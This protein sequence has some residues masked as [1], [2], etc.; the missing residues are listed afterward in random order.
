M[1]PFVVA[2]IFDGGH[3]Q[4]DTYPRQQLRSHDHDALPRNFNLSGGLT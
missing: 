1:T 4:V 3:A 2:I